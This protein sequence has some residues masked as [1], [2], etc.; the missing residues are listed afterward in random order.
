MTL[1]DKITA[2][3]HDIDQKALVSQ[4]GYHNKTAGAKSL[5]KFLETKSIH[6]WLKKGNFD[7]HHTS[8][9][10]LLALCEILDIDREDYIQTIEQS[11]KRQDA[12]SCMQNPYISIDTG[13]RRTTQSIIVLMAMGSKNRIAIDKEEIVFKSDDDILKM[14]S[15]M[16]QK[17][18][19][20]TQGKLDMWGEIQHYVYYHVDGKRYFF[21]TA[22]MLCDK[23]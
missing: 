17:H 2:K 5:K 1:H 10:F 7:N 23:D 19:Q 21:D 14:I 15:Q 11:K 9:T 18:Y 12:I 13:F 4:M 8:E 20:T 16:I 6:Q 3:L 22:G